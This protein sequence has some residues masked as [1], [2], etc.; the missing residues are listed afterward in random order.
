MGIAENDIHIDSIEILW[1]KCYFTSATD[2]SCSDEYVIIAGYIK[3]LNCDPLETHCGLVQ[4]VNQPTHRGNILDKVFT[5]R[6]DCFST[7]VS[8][9]L[10]KTKHLYVLISPD[11]FSKCTSQTRTKINISD[12]RAHNIDYLR[13]T[14]GTH[15]WSECLA[16]TDIHCVYDMF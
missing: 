16:S 15:D 1:L 11:P 6:P 5:N 13:Y 12:L 10:V 7:L 9:S 2:S 3:M 14:V 4:L 8:K